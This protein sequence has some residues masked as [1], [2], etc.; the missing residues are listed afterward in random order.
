MMFCWFKKWVCGEYLKKIEEI[1]LKHKEELEDKIK[2][3]VVLKNIIDNQKEEI[4]RLQEKII[5]LPE[6]KLSERILNTKL[7]QI[8]KKYL[9]RNA[10]VYLLD[11]QYY[12]PKKEDLIKLLKNTYVDKLKY[13]SDLFDCDDFAIRLWG[14]TSQGKWAWTTLG[15]ACG[16]RHAFNVVVLEDE[17]LYIIEPQSDRLIPFEKASKMY[18]PIWLIVI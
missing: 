4:D 14:I 6:P 8:L 7:K 10:Q 1:K 11:Y 17:N 13:L 5:D 3:I 12:L 16:N 15:F 18:I 2:T 9:K